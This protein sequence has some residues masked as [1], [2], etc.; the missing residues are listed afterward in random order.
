MRKLAGRIVLITTVCLLLVTLLASCGGGTKT[1]L[2]L[3]S[4]LVPEEGASR[5]AD[6]LLEIAKMMVSVYDTDFDPREMLVAASRGYDMTAEGFDDSKIDP[7]VDIGFG[8]SDPEGDES[9]V[10]D[11]KERAISAAKNVIKAANDR[12]DEGDKV[13]NEYEATLNEADVNTLLKAFRTKVDLNGG[14]GPFDGILS[15]IG[16]V[17]RWMTNTLTFGS[18]LAG[19]C[20]FAVIIEILMLPFAIKQQKNSIRQATLRPKEMAIRKKYKGRNDQVTMQKMQQEIQ[21]FYQRENFSPYSGCWSLLIQ[22]PIIMALYS[23]IIDPLHY[24]MGQAAGVSSALDTYYSAARAAG[25]LGGSLGGNG[26]IA[27]LSDIK[28][29]GIELLEGLKNFAYF[30]NGAE[31]FESLSAVAN[32]IPNFNIGSVNFG[33]APSTG[34]ISILWL[35]PIL[36]FGAYFV[37]SKLNRKIMYQPTANEGADAKQVACSNNI[38]DITMPL[39]S[40]FFTFM[41][42]ALVGVYWIF[43]SLISLLKSFVIAKIMPLPTFTEEDYKK[44][45]REMAGKRVVKK[46]NN[47]GKVR[48]LHH[49]DD[50]DFDDTR[51]R[52]LARK[53]AIEEQ[54]RKEQ[55]EKAKNTPFAAMPM[56]ENRKKDKK[57][58]NTDQDP[59]DAD[60]DN[61]QN[62]NQE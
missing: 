11:A 18:Y 50:E 49:I 33:L 2:T 57:N 32:K 22:L 46:S 3:G 9:K 47:V 28:I 27:I 53:A 10:L 23:I 43:R 34:K 52:A 8:F 60:T 61:N 19:I 45:E 39:M 35:V 12:A 25:G 51:E 7:T 30:E 41:V 31:V 24:V 44:A 48:S 58:K 36:T 20:L 15:A 42:P 37:T 4:T 17:L 54:E 40:T 62:N 1:T 59:Q 55:E 14:N 38:M 5:S 13:G 21:E 56:K 6:E 26:T 29:K 16:S